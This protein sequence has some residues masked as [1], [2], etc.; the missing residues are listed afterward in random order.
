MYGL[1]VNVPPNNLSPRERIEISVSALVSEQF[2]YPENT[3]VISILYCISVSKGLL[4]P[5]KLE[6]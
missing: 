1:R 4:K 5:V 2:A 6:I 3:E